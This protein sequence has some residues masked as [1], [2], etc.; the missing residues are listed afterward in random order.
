MF[1]VA[2]GDFLFHL[3]ITVCQEA[4]EVLGHLPWFLAGREDVHQQGHAAVADR[5]RFPDAEEMGNADRDVGIGAIRV[6]L[7]RNHLAISEL[8]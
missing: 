5:R 1:G 6:R 7:R 8:N 4:L 3:E 2:A